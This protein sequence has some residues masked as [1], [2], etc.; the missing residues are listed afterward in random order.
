MSNPR[1]ALVIG[2]GSAPRSQPRLKQAG[3]LANR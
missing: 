3:S 1:T 2:A